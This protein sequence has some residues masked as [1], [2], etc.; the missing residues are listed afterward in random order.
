VSDADITLDAGESRRFQH[1]ARCVQQDVGSFGRFLDFGCGS[2]GFLTAVDDPSGSGFEVGAPATF[3]V[4]HSQVTTGNFWDVLGTPGFEIG[5]FDLITSF[6][7]FEHLPDLDRYV[8]ALRSLL[9][10]GGHL[11]IGLPDVGSWNARL[12][13]ARW[14]CY[15]LEHLWFFNRK[16]LAAYMKRAGFREIKHRT[17][18]YHVPV[19][20][21][22]RRVA[23]TYG[24]PV[25]NFGPRFS[26]LLIPVPIGLIYGAFK[27]EG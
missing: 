21:I 26:N 2:G 15:L 8:Q 19:A 23:Q 4:G 5:S 6:Y 12:A 11:V 25:P 27:L 9:K 3:T 24:L 18:P 17:V 10:P 14:N 16:T 1:L 7:V 22:V 20:H 13:G